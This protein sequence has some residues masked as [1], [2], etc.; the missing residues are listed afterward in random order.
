MAVPYNDYYVSSFAVKLGSSTVLGK[1]NKGEKY[2]YLFNTE[3]GKFYYLGTLKIQLFQQKHNV[4][5]KTKIENEYSIFKDKIERK[6]GSVNPDFQKIELAEYLPD[7]E[8]AVHE[9]TGSLKW[10]KKYANSTIFKPITCFDNMILFNSVDTLY[11]INDNSNIIWKRGLDITGD[12]YYGNWWS[13][14]NILASMQNDFIIDREHDP[15]RYYIPARKNISY[16]IVADSS[17]NK[18]YYK[19]ASHTI[20]SLTINNEIVNSVTT[21]KHIWSN[22]MDF[23]SEILSFTSGRAVGNYYMKDLK[24]P[25]TITDFPERQIAVQ[26]RT[27]SNIQVYDGKIYSF[28]ANNN[29]KWTYDIGTNRSLAED[30][31]GNIYFNGNDL[32]IY[33]LDSDGKLRW[34]YYIDTPFTTTPALGS[35]GTVYVGTNDGMIY[36]IEN[37]LK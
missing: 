22:S 15:L 34:K 4:T 18:I 26:K 14:E 30:D 1:F 23:E 28:D 27:K 17:E 35:D 16:N 11:S 36:A 8:V 20:T 12:Y 21:K 24:S 29:L 5:Y 32:Y 10:K 13:P 3:P 33:S 19:S 7:K 9:N 25:I 37:A 2:E 6:F 31:N